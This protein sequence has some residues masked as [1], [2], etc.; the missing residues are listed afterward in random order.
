MAAR[1]GMARW[2]RRPVPP[3]RLAL[4][5]VGALAI[6]ATGAAAA[7]ANSAASRRLKVAPAGDVHSKSPPPSPRP[8]PPPSPPPPPP[9]C[10]GHTCQ[11][12]SP[13]PR[14][15][16]PPLPPKPSPPPPKP[17][18]PPPR[19]TF[20]KPPLSPTPPP[21]A[22]QW[23]V[24]GSRGISQGNADELEIAI[25]PANNKPV[26]SFVENLS[27]ITVMRWTGGTWQ[28]LGQRGMNKH[29]NG[30]S[31]I[32][33]EGQPGTLGVNAY[34]PRLAVCPDGSVHVGFLEG[35]YDSNGHASVW[36]WTGSSWQRVG[37]PGFSAESPVFG[38]AAGMGL[39]T[40]RRRCSRSTGQSEWQ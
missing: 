1:L 19:I 14:P 7:E 10:D 9:P 38:G 24:V 20:I 37:P 15:N 32:P 36:R 5:L 18:P 21:P 8:P 3:I 39:L 17:S 2:G 28:V 12:F 22:P 27:N 13:P 23:R 34:F 11:R 26:V 35:S 30:T 29:L 6:G 25:D 40:G 4:L 16:P 33:A 31:T